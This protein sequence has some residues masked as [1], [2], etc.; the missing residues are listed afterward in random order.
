MDSRGPRTAGVVGERSKYIEGGRRLKLECL[1]VRM[2]TRVAIKSVKFRLAVNPR[3]PGEGSS[4]Q[5]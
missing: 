5:G 2:Q 1:E 4:A 3:F